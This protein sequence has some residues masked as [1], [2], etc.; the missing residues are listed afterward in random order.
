MTFRIAQP[1]DATAI[2][3]LHAKSWQE[4]YTSSMSA[5]YL[6]NVAPQER[7]QVWNDRFNKPLPNRWTLLAEE[8]DQLI[9]FICMETN[10]D[11]KWGALLDNL[12]V[13]SIFQGRGIG[14]ELMQRGAEFLRNEPQPT[15]FY[16]WVLTDNESAIKFYQRIGGRQEGEART[17]IL[18]GQE[19]AVYRYVWEDLSVL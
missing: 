3:A 14:R 2:A 16:L 6:E 12:H 17:L 10:D 9:G 19:T 1:T 15:G 18:V 7:L 4:N 8:N 13:N 11:P 5:E